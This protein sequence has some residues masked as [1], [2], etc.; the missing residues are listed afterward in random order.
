MKIPFGL[1][2]GSWGLTGKTRKIAEA[3]YYYTGYQLELELALIHNETDLAKAKAL[4]E[5]DKK[6]NKVSEYE[7]DQRL[8]KLDN[9]DETKQKVALLDIDLKHGKITQ[10]EHEKKRAD[11]LQEPW[12]SMPK[13]SW[14]PINKQKTFFELDYNDHFIKYL[15]DNEYTGSDDEILNHWLNDIC[16]SVIEEINGVD[17]SM[18]TPTR[19]GD[20]DKDSE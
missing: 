15:R 14:D 10:L 3:E 18:A 9:T 17:V 8:A 1:L 11:L 12:I 6:Y 2:P 4:L 5:I 16:I 13:I 19:R 20:K 7:Y